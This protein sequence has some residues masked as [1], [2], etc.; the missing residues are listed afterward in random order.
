MKS[1]FFRA[2]LNWIYE[3]FKKDT[4]KMLVVTGT[5]G[6]ALSSLA[7]MGAILFNPKID[8]DQKSFLLPQEFLDAVFNVG[9]FFAITTLTKKSISKLASTGKIA[10][11]KVREFLHKNKDLYGD[12]VGKYDF[13]LDEVL[14][15][16]AKFP[17]DSYYTYKNY[18]TTVGTVGA[19]ILSCNI[20]TPILSNSLAADVQKEYFTKKKDLPKSQQ[21]TP[22]NYSS[23]MRI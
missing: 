17:K 14:K 1:S 8:F 5:L 13:D 4:S 23:G 20:V 19:S 21:I 18:V 22:I 6:W 3:N 7:Q 2:P 15:K 16:D 9:A 11:K 12:K 10:P